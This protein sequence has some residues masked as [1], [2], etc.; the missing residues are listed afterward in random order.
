M[1]KSPKFIVAKLSRNLNQF[2]LYV[3]NGI[4]IIVQNTSKTYHKMYNRANTSKTYHYSLF[5]PEGIFRWKTDFENMCAFLYLGRKRG[6]VSVQIAYILFFVYLQ[7]EQR[8]EYME[9]LRAKDLNQELASQM[10]DAM[11]WH[12]NRMHCFL[13][14]S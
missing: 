6:R 14:S 3:L 7:P 12:R 10:S 11:F 4:Y 2:N 1:E 9:N 8:K 13:F 5:H